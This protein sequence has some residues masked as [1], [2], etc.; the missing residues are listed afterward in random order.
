VYLPTIVDEDL[1]HSRLALK[2]KKKTCENKEA[3]YYF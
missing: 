2:S 1:T 3:T